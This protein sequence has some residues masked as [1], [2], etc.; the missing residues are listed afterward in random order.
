MMIN[1]CRPAFLRTENPQIIEHTVAFRLGDEADADAFWARVGALADI[2][3]VQQFRKLRQI[4][5]K[6][7]FTH[8]LSMHFDSQ[9]EYDAYN[10]HPVHL[11][12]VNEVWLPNVAD[13]I[14][15]D[16]VDV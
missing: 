8:A 3:G 9:T 10:N 15:L 4:G 16:Y 5:L 13:F 1:R 14:E 7:D 12:F 6:N 2:G 11:A